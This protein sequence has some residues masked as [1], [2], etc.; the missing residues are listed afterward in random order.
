VRPG[1][2]RGRRVAP[3]WLQQRKQRLGR[4]AGNVR[5]SREE[6]AHP[7]RAGGS[8]AKSGTGSSSLGIPGQCVP[9]VERSFEHN[10]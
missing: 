5:R 7:S 9:V 8:A 10:T 6:A 1:V 2:G 3:R 4:P